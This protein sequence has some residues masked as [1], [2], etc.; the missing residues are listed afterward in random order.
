MSKLKYRF[1]SDEEEYMSEDARKNYRIMNS[2]KLQLEWVKRQLEY[3]S[4]QE[5]YTP[6]LDLKVGE[7]YEF[8][9]GVNVNC[10]FSN[11][12]YGV[13]VANSYENNP[14]VIV[15]PLKSNRN[16]ANPSSDINLGFIEGL[17]TD[18]ETLAVVNQIRSLDKMRLY[19]NPIIN[20]KTNESQT[21]KLNSKQIQLLKN[22]I[23]KVL[24]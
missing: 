1:K 12:H 7:V 17:I 13:V 11:R 19:V 20:E 14:L 21:I 9:F 15:C 6:R 22:G 24:I 10:E 3:V 23:K 8:D 16:G 2:L 4:Y 18:R 5:R